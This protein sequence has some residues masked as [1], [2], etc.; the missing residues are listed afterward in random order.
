MSDAFPEEISSGS[1]V[2]KGKCSKKK[3]K[4]RKERFQVIDLPDVEPGYLD[5]SDRLNFSVTPSPCL[6]QYK[7]KLMMELKLKLP[8]PMEKNVVREKYEA[9]LKSLNVKEVC[10]RAAVYGLKNSSK[11]KVV[12]QLLLLWDQ[13]HLSEEEK[14]KLLAFKTTPLNLP[15]HKKKKRKLNNQEKKN[16]KKEKEK[17]EL[18]NE[19]IL[20]IKNS[21]T[22]YEKILMFDSIEYEKLLQQ[23]PMKLPNKNFLPT[24]L[25]EYGITYAKSTGE[26]RA[27]TKKKKKTKNYFKGGKY[28]YYN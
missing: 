11:G 18:Q 28:K 24:M 4:K 25:D 20:Y 13:K 1:A 16:R 19:L 23:I 22:W 2:K 14:N 5:Q 6:G 9:E 21:D 26:N 27:R 17:I 7:S 10:K 8:S 12:D 3:R 15:K